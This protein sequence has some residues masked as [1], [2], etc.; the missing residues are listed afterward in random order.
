MP[1]VMLSSWR[2]VTALQ[3]GYCGSHL[4]TVSS[5]ESAPFASN[6]RISAAVN[7]F[8]MLPI[9]KRLSGVTG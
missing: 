5:I 6:L 4:P 7:D 2:I 8:V 1:L 3:A 9:W